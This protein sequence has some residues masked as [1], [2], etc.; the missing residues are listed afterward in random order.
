[1]TTTVLV[2]DEYGAAELARLADVRA[3][4]YDPAAPLADQLPGDELRQVDVLVPPLQGG[5]RADLLA[6][7]PNLRLVQ[8]LTAGYEA[9]EGLV[10]E[11]V[12][13]STGRGA[14]GGSTAEWVLATLLA[15][16]RDLPAFVRAQDRGEWDYHLTGTLIGARVLVIGAGDVAQQIVRRLEPFGTHTVMVGRTARDGVR[17]MAELPDLVPEQDV[18][19]LA[20]PLTEQTRG[21]ADAGFLARMRDGAVLVNVARGPV[22]DTDALLAELRT[23]RLRAALDVTDPEPLPA[24][25]PLWHAP[26][27]LITPHVGGSVTGA[28]RRAYAIAAEQIEQFI[29]GRD[30]ENLVRDR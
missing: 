5:D 22:V 14:H 23:H 21:L 12:A 11:A 3:V 6:A 8:L 29:K 15:L 9:W 28:F 26:G 7:L 25:H 10:P 2:P 24:D 20:V 27:L 16:Q 30:P 18:V 1:M 19:V 17:A 4:R 13:L